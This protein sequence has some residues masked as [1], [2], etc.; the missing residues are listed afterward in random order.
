MLENLQEGID[1]SLSYSLRMINDAHMLEADKR[2]LSAIPLYILALEELGK[3][4]HLIAKH[5]RRIRVTEEEWRK[6]FLR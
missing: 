6:L 4:Q 5:V 3:S 2:F 1:A